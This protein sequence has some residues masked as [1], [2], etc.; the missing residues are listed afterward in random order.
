MKQPVTIVIAD[1][2]PIIRLGLTRILRKESTYSIIGESSN[3]TDA[4]AM[5]RKLKPDVAILDVAMPGMDG[6][7]VI[8]QVRAEKLD[9]KL[10][11]LTMYK[12]HAYFKQATEL[13]VNGYLLKDNAVVDIIDCL[14]AVMRG[15]FFKTSLLN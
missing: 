5:I 1:D 15:E 8:R 10:I 7:E 14:K 11:I 9:V 2:F 12:D 4:L 6:L 3:G 13:G